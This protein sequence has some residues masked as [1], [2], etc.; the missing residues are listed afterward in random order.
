M[1]S[2]KPTTVEWVHEHFEVDK[3]IDE[4]IGVWRVLDGDTDVFVVGV[5]RPSLLG[6]AE[7]WLV[8]GTVTKRVLRARTALTDLL[9]AHFPVTCAHA[10]G[11]VNEKFAKFFGF[12]ATGQQTVDGEVWTRFT[13]P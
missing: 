3:Q 13:L 2:V 12:Q 1:I 11:P 9:R 6:W 8:M 5:L 4:S 10:R 7:L